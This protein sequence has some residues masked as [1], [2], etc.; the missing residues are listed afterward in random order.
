[1]P[2]I[3]PGMKTV[4]IVALELITG[5]RRRRAWTP[6]EKKLIVAASAEPTATFLILRDVSR[7]TWLA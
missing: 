7:E 5:G 2:G 3:K 4:T 6:E 1:M